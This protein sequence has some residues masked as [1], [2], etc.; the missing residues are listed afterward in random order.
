MTGPLSSISC[1]VVTLP[2]KD[3]ESPGVFSFEKTFIFA[4]QGTYVYH[5]H[6]S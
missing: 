5:D 3:F 2:I 6:S 4:I 1:T